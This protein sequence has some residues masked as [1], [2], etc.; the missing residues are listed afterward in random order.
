LLDVIANPERADEELLSWAAETLGTTTAQLPA[1][2]P[3]RFDQGEIN[4]ALLDLRR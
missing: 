2:D 4:A 3:A 1:Y